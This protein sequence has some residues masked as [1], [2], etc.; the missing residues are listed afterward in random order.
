MKRLIINADDFGLTNGINEGIILAHKR[1]ILTSTTLIPNMPGFENAVKLAKENKTLGVGIHLNI[2]RGKPVRRPEEVSSLLNKNGN[3]LTI[4]PF[5]KK[6]ILGKIEAEQV[7]KEFRAQIEK[8]LD[9][10][11]E[12]THFDSEKHIHSIPKIMGIVIKLA[13]E[14]KIPKI[15]FINEFCLSFDIVRSLKSMVVSCLNRKMKR[16][17][18]KAGILIPDRFY[19]ICGSGRMNSKNLIKILTSIPDGVTEIMVH[20]GIIDNDYIKIEQEYGSYYLKE[21][22]ERELEALIDLKVKEIIEEENIQL[23]N[24]RDLN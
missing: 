24:Y 1:G 8:V 2:I 12:I 20:P 4:Y 3:F 22:R 21:E 13:K 23:I 9:E 18:L 17:I 15:R 19:G 14:Y 7:E 11:I 10:G 6:F 5:I 16:N